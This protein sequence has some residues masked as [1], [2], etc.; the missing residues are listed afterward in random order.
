MSAIFPP[1]SPFISAF[2][3][4]VAQEMTPIVTVSFP[5][6]INTAYVTATTANG[7]TVTQANSQAVLQTSTAANGSALL[8]SIYAARYSPGQG[9]VW[10]GT[11]AFTTGAAGSQQERGIGDANDGF[12]FGYQGA[13]FGIFRRQNGTDFFTA[14]SAWN[15]GPIFSGFDPT[16]GNVYQIRYQWLG[17]GAIRYYIE[18]PYTGVLQ[19]VHTIYYPN[20][21]VIPSIFNPSLPDHTRVVN[22]G[23]ATNLTV[24]VGSGGIYSEGPYNS[25]G[26]RFSVGNRKTAITA[27]TSV[28]ALRCNATF[29]SKTNRGRIHVDSIGSAISGN[30]DSQYRLV[31]NPTLGGVPSFTDIN[32]NQSIAAFDIAGTTVTGGREIRRG[33]SSGNF[34]LSEDISSLE[35]RLNPGDVLVAAAAS[36]AAT[37]IAANLS[38]SWNEEL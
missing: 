5:Y 14:Q 25:L 20:Q 35:I 37:P 32:T 26:A 8:E 24:L 4:L 28:F 22:S 19:L 2:G 10:R 17:Y 31:L 21:A 30:V 29:Q 7:G 18:N 12:F 33:P 34:Q 13:T 27:E 6:N 11:A 15:G 9:M 23:N 1:D 38:L 3:E 36:L 16:K